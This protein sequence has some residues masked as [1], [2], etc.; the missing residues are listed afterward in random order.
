MIHE[1]GSESRFKYRYL[2]V[3]VEYTSPMGTKWTYEHDE[4]GNILTLTNPLGHWLA[5]SQDEQGL[6]IESRTPGGLVISRR[7]GP[8]LRWVEA[9]DQI[10]LLSRLEYDGAAGL[11]A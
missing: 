9:S 5:C 11:L 6:V 10:S 7:Y 1:D 3:L 2:H 8:R 4:Q